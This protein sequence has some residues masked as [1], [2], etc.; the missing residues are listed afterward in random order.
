LVKASIY[1]IAVERRLAVRGGKRKKREEHKGAERE[2]N[3]RFKH[4]PET[5]LYSPLQK[6]CGRIVYRFS[7]YVY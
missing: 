3:P 5:H 2:G 1:A 6:N 7:I 4:L